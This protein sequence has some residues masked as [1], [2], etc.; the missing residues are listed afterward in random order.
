MHGTEVELKALDVLARDINGK[1]IMATVG[2][3]HIIDGI[4]GAAV[5]EDL[6]RDLEC[7]KE[8]TLNK[9][10]NSN[11]VIRAREARYINLNNEITV[12]NNIDLPR[13]FRGRLTSISIY[14]SCRVFIINLPQQPSLLGGLLSSLSSRSRPWCR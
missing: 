2:T 12:R 8:C 10:C 5:E 3:V 6:A 14:L 1:W 13:G 4:V 7:S 9:A 11:I